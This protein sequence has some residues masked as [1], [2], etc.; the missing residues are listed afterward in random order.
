M[1]RSLWFSVIVIE[2]VDDELRLL[3]ED[4]AIFASSVKVHDD[5]LDKG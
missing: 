2:V 1:V 5:T 3:N 4:A